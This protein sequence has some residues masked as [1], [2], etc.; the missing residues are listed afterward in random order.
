MDEPGFQFLV[1]IVAAPAA[2]A[3][4]FAAADAAAGAA[5]APAA[6]ADSGTATDSA[7]ASY[8]YHPC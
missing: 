5:A 6:A 2:D 4:T 3:A 7:I 8:R 1:R